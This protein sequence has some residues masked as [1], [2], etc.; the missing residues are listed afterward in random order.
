LFVRQ[1]LDDRKSRC[2][3]GAARVEKRAGDSSPPSGF[4]L[5]DCRVDIALELPQVPLD[6][7]AYVGRTDFIPIGSFYLDDNDHILALVD[8]DSEIDPSTARTDAPFPFFE[9]CRTDKVGEKSGLDLIVK[10][11]PGPQ[12][13][14]GSR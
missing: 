13:L 7:A 12:S 8:D 6:V 9:S 11:L 2:V 1:R 10:G 4:E 14:D 3:I 5:L